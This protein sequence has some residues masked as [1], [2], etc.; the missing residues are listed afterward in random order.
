MLER[1]ERRSKS[2]VVH[3]L[4]DGAKERPF[5]GGRQ[6]QPANSVNW[7]NANLADLEWSRVC[8]KIG[9]NL[10]VESSNLAH[11]SKIISIVVFAA[12]FLAASRPFWRP[13]P[14]S[15]SN[16]EF[17]I[18]AK[19]QQQFATVFLVGICI[20]I[21]GFL[22]KTSFKCKE[23]TSL[24]HPYDF[25]AAKPTVGSSIKWAS[26]AHRYGNKAVRSSV[27]VK[28]PTAFL[29]LRFE[30]REFSSFPKRRSS[31][32]FSKFLSIFLG[33]FPNVR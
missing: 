6:R 25:R 33:R 10:F 5:S 30:A 27:A 8:P 19:L 7:P 12:L 18:E 11:Q 9:P 31:K 29:P 15:A 4:Y 20:C 17:R 23:K 24:W 26:S 32:C 14:A 22:I 28:W 13:W 3:E 2:L 16:R 1:L 21:L